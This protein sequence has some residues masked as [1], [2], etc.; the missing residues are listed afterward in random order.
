LKKIKNIGILAHVDAGK[1]TITEHFLFL[2]GAIKSIGNVD[3]GSSV[4]DSMA[5][6]KERGISIRSTGVSFDWQDHQIN[7]IDTPGHADFSAEVERSLAVMDGVILVISAVEGVQSHTITLWEAIKKRGLPCLFFINKLD[8]DGA[9]FQRVLSEIKKEL[10]CPVFPVNVPNLGNTNELSISSLFNSE[11]T[12]EQQQYYKEQSIESLADLDEEIL[13]KY[14]EG[15]ELRWDEVRNKLKELSNKQKLVPVFT[16]VAKLGIGIESLLRGIIDFLPD[17]KMDS[18]T[19][20]SA[21]VYKLE[22]DNVLGKLAHVR[23]FGGNLKTRDLINNFTLKKGGKIAQ[24]K[25]VT[26]GKMLDV[27]E[28]KAGDTGIL[29]GL[30]HIRA[31][32]VLGDQTQV[33]SIIP[34]QNPVLTVQVKPKNEKQYADLAEALFILNMEDPSLDF[35]WYKEDREMHLKLMG[36]IQVEILQSVLEQRFGISTEF[37]DPNVIYKET[38]ARTA[39]GYIEYTMPKPCWAVM[40]FKVGSGEPGSGITYNSEVSVNYIHR[41]YQ[42]EVRETIP[43]AL[44][45]GIK[46]WEVTDIKITLIGGEDHEIHSRPGDFILATPMGIMRALEKSGTKLLE[47]VYTFDIKALE[48]FLG[49]ITS[50]LTKMR[51]IFESPEFENENFTLKGKVPVSTALKYHVRLSSLTG[52]K[53]KLHFQ[54]DGY[55][56]C[57]EEHGKIREYKGV[58][59]LDT[60]QWILHKRGAFKADERKF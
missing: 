40:R 33:P 57:P 17:A 42:N 30:Q 53:G 45:Q 16:G 47:P 58:N 49:T 36:S 12:D 41:K 19:D 1:T 32:D 15:E 18:N 59:P 29:T 44:V 11:V 35:M 10:H 56:D 26:A 39:E 34:V 7:L 43:K 27:G 46:G 51:G 9:D 22:H 28:L 14:L 25:K 54:F 38:P 48:E 13:E 4:S 55:Q 24:I 37:A 6:E 31:G 8:R 23:I 21:M 2:S 50:D 3:K 52:G 60:S 5:L 20:V